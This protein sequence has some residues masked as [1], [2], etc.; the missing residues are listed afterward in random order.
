MYEP[1][2]SGEVKRPEKCPFCDG[3]ILGTLAKVISDTS[4]WRCRTCESTWTIAGQRAQRPRPPM[5]D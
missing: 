2:S 3:K 1:P 4:V 5:R